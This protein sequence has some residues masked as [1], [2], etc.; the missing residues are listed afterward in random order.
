M[1]GLISITLGLMALL[2]SC[3]NTEQKATEFDKN[4]AFEPSYTA[5][6]YFF[7]TLDASPLE[8]DKY[9]AQLVKIHID[10]SNNVSGQFYYQPYGSDG[11]RGSLSGKLDRE[12][13]TLLVKRTAL[14]EGERYSQ[15]LILKLSDEALELGYD[16]ENG[17][18][19]RLPLVTQNLYEQYWTRFKNQQ[20]AARTNTS[21]R[22]RL[23]QLQFLKDNGVSAGAIAQLK[24]MEVM[25]D[26]DNDYSTTEYLIYIMDP[27]LCGSGG[28][29]LFV[30]D[31]KGKTLSYSTVTRPPVY[32]PLLSYKEQ[33]AQQGQWNDLYVYSDGMRQLRFEGEAYTTNASMGELMDATTLSTTPEMYMLVMD[34][35]NY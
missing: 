26:L 17:D 14:A 25:V 27:M 13:M 10:S 34:Y 9:N 15:D 28:C 11:S 6:D 16:D 19:V 5:G 35:L 23:E 4:V 29:N 18:A 3:R 20:L 32:L 7:G 2:S 8:A 30:V 33:Q 22:Q 31:E 21:D 12:S 1:R 24:F